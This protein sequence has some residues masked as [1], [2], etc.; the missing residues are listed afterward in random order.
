MVE[1][2]HE[3]P[4]DNFRYTVAPGRYILPRTKRAHRQEHNRSIV[5]TLIVP[6]GGETV[7]VSFTSPAYLDL[8]Y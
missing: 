4:A 2:G 6:Q 3:G 7:D 5:G 1:N 8:A